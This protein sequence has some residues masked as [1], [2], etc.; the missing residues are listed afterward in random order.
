M[1]DR[2]HH[3][4]VAPPADEIDRDT[5]SPI[6][7][8]PLPLPA[9]IRHRRLGTASATWRYLDAA[10]ALLFL[11]ARFDP[12]AERKQILPYTCGPNGWRWHAPP[13]PRPLYGLDRLAARPDAAVIV[14]EGEKTADA[15]ATIFTDYVAITWPG[16]SMATGKVDWSPLRGRRVVVWPD[17]DDAGRRAAADVAKAA[18]AA[19]AASVAVVPVPHTWP[20]G[21]DLADPLPVGVTLDTL[22]DM[23]AQAEAQH[24]RQDGTD[25]LALAGLVQRCAADPGAAFAPEVVQRLAELKR[26]DRAAFESLRQQLKQAGT[27]VTELDRL[28]ADH[29]GENRH[30]PTQA[31]ILIE[32]AQEGAELF[33]APDGSSFADIEVNGHRETWAIRSKGFRRWLSRAFFEATEGAPNSEAMQAALN[34]IEARA[35]FDAPE[36]MVHV[37]VAGADGRL[38]V[39]LCDDTWRAVE[40]DANGWRIVDNPPVRF[41]RAAGMQALPMPERGG[42]IDTLRI[43]LNVQS[44]NDFV[45]VVSWLLACL[46]DRGPYPLIVLSGEQGSAKST[47]S[48]VL[49][50]LID[51]NAAPLRALPRDDRDLFIAANNAHVLAFDNVSGMPGW[52]SDTLCRLATGG[53]FATRQLYT[54]QD[55]TIFDACRPVVLNG[56]EDVV[57]RPDL[58]DRALFLNL[59]PIPEERRRP[60]AEFWNDFHAE[61]PQ[62]LGALLDGVAE[63]LRRLPQTRLPGLPR[64][65]DFALWA[66]ACEGA[67]WPP[68]R[69]M[70]AYTTN[71][72]EVVASVIDAD[73]VAASV[74]ALMTDRTDWRGTASE[75]L[76]VLSEVAGERTTRAKDW[77]SNPRVLANRLRR[78][79]TFLRKSGI[80]VSFSRAGQDRTRFIHIAR[81]PLSTEPES[82]GIPASVTS[83]SSAPKASVNV[84]NDLAGLAGGRC[85]D[86]TDA[87][88]TLGGRWADDDAAGPPPIVRP[89]TLANPLK[90][91]TFAPDADAADATDAKIPTHSAPEKAVSRPA[92]ECDL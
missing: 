88:R 7:P 74:R 11:V 27:R 5:W 41:R 32:L 22:R 72:V 77:P 51:P 87:G 6:M 46:R 21:W 58:A 63:G 34:V 83:A 50:A 28:I 9:T 29:A 61:R 73:P 82:R 13:A 25:D 44:D 70:H 45:L 47:A 8:A 76:A 14:T 3:D 90:N 40:I 33:H 42:S 84:F 16:G 31:D 91:M 37:R 92:W 35:H 55:E 1:L 30:D 75:L 2:V 23:L 80:E 86:A 43:F 48:A 39:D 89:H 60:E 15:A 4:P 66:T 62:L 65:A 38:Y 81:I 54:D 71:R 24:E 56:I 17:A 20:S 19:G 36:R 18:R 85:A 59:D 53:G 49:R 69:F 57:T 12:P 10:G 26:N 68:G 52:L 67:F 79:A 78:A 64:M